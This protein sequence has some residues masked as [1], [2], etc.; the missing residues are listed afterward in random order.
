MIIKKLFLLSFLFSLILNSSFGQELYFPSVDTEEWETLSPEQLGWNPE[1]LDN[2]HHFLDS[3]QSK[4]FILLKDGKIVLEWYF[5]E[6]TTDSVWYWASAGKGMTA[7]LTGILQSEGLLD[8]EDPTNM[9]LGD[10]WTQAPKE[11]ED[12]ITIRHQLSMVSGLNDLIPERDCTLPS[13]LEYLEDPEQRWAYYNAPYTLITNV[14]EEASN[15]SLN[16]LLFN[17]ISRKTGINAAY[18]PIDFNRIIFSRPRNFVRFGLLM[19]AEGNWDGEQILEDTAYFNQM[20]NSSQELNKSYGYLWWLNGK[21]SFMLP[22]LQFI[23]N[24]PLF[25]DA[26]SDTYAALG[27]N[28]QILSVT[29]S[30]NLVFIRMGNNPGGAAVPIS[31]NN[32]IWTYLNKLSTTSVS[33]IEETD[34]FITVYPNPATEWLHIDHPENISSVKV[35]LVCPLGKRVLVTNDKRISVHGM[36]PGM[37]LL[38]ITADSSVQTQKILILSP[39]R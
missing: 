21:E 20:I 37:Y 14:L 29:P 15:M 30:K 10:G 28:G 2:L 24:G 8:I 35:E 16:L 22:Q 9:Y 32:D 39:T 26:Q 13:C 33:E 12:L 17:R 36:N 4:A 18:I 11:K 3:S 5:G 31:L 38:K 27:L 1:Y 19:L 34:S 6:F 23:F 25:P 7:F